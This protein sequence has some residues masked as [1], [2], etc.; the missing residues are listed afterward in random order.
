MI[1]TDQ[2]SVNV[3]AVI[4]PSRVTIFGYTSPSSRIELSS[5]RVFAATY[6]DDSGF[7]SF[8]KTLLPRPSGEL[9]LV[10]IDHVNRRTLPLCFPQPP[11]TNYHTDIGPFILPPTITISDG[12][13]SGQSLPDSPLQI[14]FYQSHSLAPVVEAF[15][16]PTLQT[17]TDSQGNFDLNLIT[18]YHTDYHLYATTTYQDNPSPKSNTLAYSLPFRFNFFITLLPLLFLIPFFLLRRRHPRYLPALY[19]KSLVKLPLFP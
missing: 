13:A 2:K 10:S 11:E 7:F 6:S 17:S 1:I 8:D 16:L 15:S 5:P 3:S 12:I 18:A 4:D 9:C 19:P 14:H